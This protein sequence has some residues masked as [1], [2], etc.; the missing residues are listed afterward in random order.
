MSD[1]VLDVVIAGVGGQGT[2][3]GAAVLGR[4]GVIAGYKVRGIDNRGLAQRGGAVMSHVR[5]G[6]D[7]NSAMVMDGEA[8]VLLGFEPSEALRRAYFIK[9][10]G[11]ILL[12]TKPIPPITVTIGRE[13]YP[14]IDGIIRTFKDDAGAR[15]L[16]FDASELANEAGNPITLNTVMLGA[17]SALDT[18]L[19]PGHL[20]AAIRE[21]FRR[22]LQ[23]VNL[24]AFQLGRE[25][26]LELL[27]SRSG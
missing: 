4:A 1:D 12:N 23:D 8:D 5:I 3:T 16:A 7:V 9:Q 22:K 24:V 11:W 6:R 26:A 13:S 15:V 25:K 27:R 18:L 10:G 21:S 14:D 2:I 17:F 19:R 20:E